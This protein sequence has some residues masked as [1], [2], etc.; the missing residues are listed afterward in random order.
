MSEYAKRKLEAELEAEQKDSWL[1]II[2]G[3]VILLVGAIE[4]Y[5]FMW[6]IL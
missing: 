5:I 3:S 6:V 2:A 4:I 1:K